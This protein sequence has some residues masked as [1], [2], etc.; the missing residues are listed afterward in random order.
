MRRYELT[1]AEWERVAPLL[2]PHARRGRPRNDDRQIINALLWLARTGAP[3]RDLPEYYGPWRTVATRFYRWTA[4]ELWQRI[5]AALHRAADAAGKLDW[6]LHMV[7]STIIRAHQH[8]AGARGGSTGR[9]WV[10]HAAA[11]R[12][13][14]TSAA[15]D[16]ANP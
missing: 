4:S 13:S 6:S 2:P 12:P 14:F 15:M 16:G 5:L 11:S 8:A 3:W 10:A 9:R 1:D 7:D